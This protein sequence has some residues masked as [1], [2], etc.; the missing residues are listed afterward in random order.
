[1]EVICLLRDKYHHRTYITDVK[2]NQWKQGKEGWNNWSVGG[3]TG[4]T[5]YLKIGAFAMFAGMLAPEE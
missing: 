1:M 4:R 2:M 3:I 5:T